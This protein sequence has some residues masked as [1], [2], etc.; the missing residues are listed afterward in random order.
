MTT[1][2]LRLELMDFA[3]YDILVLNPA[4]ITITAV[5]DQSCPFFFSLANRRLAMLLAGT[6]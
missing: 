6:L 4:P 3:R 2:G 1:R 5:I